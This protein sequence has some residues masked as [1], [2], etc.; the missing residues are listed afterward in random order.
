VPIVTGPGQCCGQCAS[1]VE[2][3]VPTCDVSGL[4]GLINDYIKQY[5]GLSC[6]TSADCTLASLGGACRLDC[7]TALNTTAAPIIEKAVTAY[8]NTY[9]LS[10]PQTNL[11]CPPVFTSAQCQSG[12]CV[13]L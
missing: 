12:V 1:Y 10:C 9:C 13:K 2:A 5:N 7:G 3:G 4:D 8:S 6:Q 11:A